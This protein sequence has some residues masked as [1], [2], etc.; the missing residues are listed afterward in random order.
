M[1]GVLQVTNACAANGMCG[2]GLSGVFACYCLVHDC[3]VSVSL[4]GVLQMT[5]ACEAFCIKAVN[6]QG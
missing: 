5:N 2:L 3:L 6:R 1:V 4:M